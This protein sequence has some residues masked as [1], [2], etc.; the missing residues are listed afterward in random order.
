MTGSEQREAARRGGSY[1]IWVAL[2]FAG[3]I[4]YAV[5]F[6]STTLIVV[7]M[8]L[9]LLHILYIPLWLKKQR[10]FLCSTA[11]ARQ[12]DFTPERL[13]LFHFGV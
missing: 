8:L 3:P 1:G 11:W 5:V 10:E 12:N 9:M 7:A 13:R 6:T 2:T 4:S